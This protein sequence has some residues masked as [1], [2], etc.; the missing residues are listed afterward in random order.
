MAAVN[1]G[2]RAALY[3][4]QCR[5][6]IQES[7][8]AAIVQC[9][10]VTQVLD[11]AAA[12]LSAPLQREPALEERLSLYLQG[13]GVAA[14]ASVFRDTGGRLRA[15]I[16]GPLAGLEAQPDHLDK[17][18]AV[19]G[20]RLC[21]RAE[22]APDRMTL[23]EAEP[24]AARVG[25]ASMR[26]AGQSVCGDSETFFKTDD[27]SLYALLSDGMGSG[28]GAAR[29]SGEA[30][31]ILQ[32]FLR[33]GV[34]PEGALR[35]LGSALVL[36][37]DETGCATADILR[38]DL[39]SGKTLLCKCGAAP[40]YIRSGSKIRRIGCANTAVGLSG[41]AP[42]KTELELKP[43]TLLVMLSDGVLENASDQWLR[44]KLLHFSG[45]DVKELA[46]QLLSAAMDAHGGEDD[47]TVLCIHLATRE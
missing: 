7:R 16:S 28:E 15:E 30:L 46:A 47:M 25:V 26:R 2:L 34:E 43:D 12:G 27:G 23:L 9:R 17:L 3:R 11:A 32:R 29:L 35:I 42:E 41:C 31:S 18:S 40:T 33:A 36:C 13:A 24:L 6:R 14:A 37:G 1:D 21:T 38:L 22:A 8:S 19:L 20:T 4:R 39:F 5:A 44:D 10:E 45:T